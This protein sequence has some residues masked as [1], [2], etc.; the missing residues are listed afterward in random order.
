MQRDRDR[1]ALGSRGR[2][3]FTIRQGHGP[4]QSSPISDK[5]QAVYA[6]KKPVT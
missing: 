3:A 5:P 4:T 2:G 6:V 1:M